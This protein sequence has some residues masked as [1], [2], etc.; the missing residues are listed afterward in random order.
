[1]LRQTILVA[2]FSR[3][4]SPS[5]NFARER[6]CMNQINFFCESWIDTDRVLTLVEKF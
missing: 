6:T 3:K 5:G 1:M 2:I 4:V